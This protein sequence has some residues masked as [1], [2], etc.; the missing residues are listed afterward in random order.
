M[1]FQDL[2]QFVSFLERRGKLARLSRTFD[3]DTEIIPFYRMELLGLP[4]EQRKALLFERVTGATGRLFDMQVLA[5]CYGASDEMLLLGLGCE[6]YADAL[7]QLHRGMGEPIPPVTVGN[8][9][10][11]EVV[12]TGSEIAETGLDILPSPVEE[13][14]FSGVIRTGMPQITRDPETGKVNVGTVNG[15]FLSR[16]RIVIGMSPNRDAKG[17]LAAAQRRGE[18]LPLAIVIGCTPDLMVTGS[19]QLPYATAPDELSVAGGLSGQPIEMV[20]CKSIPLEVPAYAEAV[21]EGYISPT[22]TG[23]SLP[24]GEYPGY[25]RAELNVSPLMRVTAITH[26]KQ[27]MFTPL[28]VGFWPND[29]NT[30][31]GFGR[32]ALVYHRLKYELGLPVNEVYAPQAAGG[33]T[34]CLIQVPEGTPQDTVW[35]IL[36]AAKNATY[37]KYCIAL[38]EDGDLRSLDYLLWALCFSSRPM[39]DIRIVPGGGGGN[40]DPSIAPAG[41]GRGKGTFTDGLNDATA[42]INATRKF[43]YPPVALPERSY[44]EHARKLWQ[45]AG[46]PPVNLR[47][48]WHG[49]T[50]GFWPA[51]LERYAADLVLGKYVDVGAQASAAVSA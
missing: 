31:A 30:L 22:E 13:V 5:G 49:Y 27:A 45:E 38:D 39:R 4:A 43:A 44:M 26:R 41:S 7:E 28:T 8:G 11:H 29:S 20:R 32:S 50:L 23:P 25:M 1:A 33:T 35:E 14:G 12:H 3:K 2:R 47:Q 18:E 36:E 42:L 17:H 15:F 24:F 10:V 37:F 40:L 46:L 34:C 16:D 21:I 19:T 6:T 51:E 9:P 48:P